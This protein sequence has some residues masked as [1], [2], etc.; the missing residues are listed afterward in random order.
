MATFKEKCQL[1]FGTTDFYEVLSVNINATEKEIKKAY[2]KLSLLVHPDRVDESQ[3]EIATEKFKVL[4]KIHSILQDSNSRK[5]Y[6]D[7]GDFDEEDSAFNWK[8]YWFA[9]FKKIELKDIQ[10]Y[11]MEYIGSETEIRD[12]KRAY[13]S[14]KGNMGIMLEMIPFSNCDSEPKIIEIV[15]KM[16]DAGEVPEY[17][18][19]F[20]ESKVKKMRRR[21]KWDAEKKEAEMIDMQQL[22]KEMDANMKKRSEAFG[23]LIANLEEKYAPKKP[24]KSITDGS[25]KKPARKTRR[26]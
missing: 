15:R 24:R 25:E 3:K 13:E 12:I 19:F 10:N 26:K 9:M 20:N 2:H 17:K 1:Y 4:G 11:E 7:C 22:E 5:I 23:E 18:A 14:T 6:D 8:E 16:V 21:K